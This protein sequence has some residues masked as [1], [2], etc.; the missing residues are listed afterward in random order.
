MTDQGDLFSGDYNLYDGEPP[1]EDV[2]TSIAAAKKILPDVGTIQR[3]VFE[4][5]KNCSSEG[6]TDEQMFD[7]LGR[8]TQ[9]NTYRP[10]RRELVLMGFLVDSGRRKANRSGRD[11]VVWQ[12]RDDLLAKWEGNKTEMNAEMNVEF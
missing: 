1:H 12:I 11:A 8:L 6:S 2:D 9:Q 3:E 5:F 4:Y 10:R 7:S